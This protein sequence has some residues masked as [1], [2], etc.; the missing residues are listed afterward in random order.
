MKSL[1]LAFA[2][3]T[4]LCAT[5]QKLDFSLSAGS[6]KTY[7][8]ES[9]DKTVN[10]NYGLPLSLMTE[11]KFT[12][13]HKTW[14]VK[15][16]VHQ[17]QSTLAG[18][19]WVKKTPLDGYINSLTT[20]LLIENEIVKNQFSY[21]FNFGLGM[22]KEII[23]PQQYSSFDRSTATYSSVVLG[24]H[25]SYK[26]SRD[27]DFQVQPTLLWQDPFKSIGV[28]TAR[29]KANF[30]GEDLSAVVNFGIRYTLIK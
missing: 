26:L 2:L 23:Q 12:P 1:L 30:A 9:I 18:E 25:L 3:S 19:N 29:R 8:F 11:I 13:K 21:G 7:T 4:T 10:V 27:F 15:A 5:A 16:R 6:G 17:L 24:G 28:L 22:T 20:S 14:G